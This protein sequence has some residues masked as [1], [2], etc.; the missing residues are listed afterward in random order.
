MTLDDVASQPRLRQVTL[1][2]IGFD[3]SSSLSEGTGVEEDGE[4]S[5]AT[6]G[7]NVVWIKSEAFGAFAMGAGGGGPSVAFGLVSVKGGSMTVVC[8]PVVHVGIVKNSSNV[9]TRGLQ[10]FQPVVPN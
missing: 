10:H 6:R 3:G 2:G 4:G 9:R 8:L 1:G 7:A 5:R